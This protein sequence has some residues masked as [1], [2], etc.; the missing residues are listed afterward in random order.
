MFVIIDYSL[1]F[2]KLYVNRL[3]VFESLRKMKIGGHSRGKIER[4]EITN[5][6]E[7]GIMPYLM[8]DVFF[9]EAQVPPQI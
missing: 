4:G 3:S 2:P 8:K 6:K 1:F 5:R 9:S 7:M